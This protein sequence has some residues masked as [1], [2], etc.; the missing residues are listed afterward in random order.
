[1]RK[2]QN[3][4]HILCDVKD[5]L[6]SVADG[7]EKILSVY[8]D[9]DDDLIVTTTD[10]KEKYEWSIGFGDETDP[11]EWLNSLSPELIT[12][13]LAAEKDGKLCSVCTHS[14][15]CATLHAGNNDAPC[16]RRENM[17]WIDLERLARYG[18]SGEEAD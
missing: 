7:C 18:T 5:L 4:E 16:N 14:G 6:Q 2:A 17:D 9:G 1:M 3:I 13:F 12:K 8:F 10:G 15:R 11:E